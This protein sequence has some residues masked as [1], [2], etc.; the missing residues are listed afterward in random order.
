MGYSD[1]NLRSTLHILAIWKEESE[2]RWEYITILAGC[3]SLKLKRSYSL[4]IFL[5]NLYS[6]REFIAYKNNKRDL[7]ILLQQLARYLARA[8][9]KNTVAAKLVDLENLENLGHSP[10]ERSSSSSSST[11][12]HNALANGDAAQDE[13]IPQQNMAQWTCPSKTL[14]SQLSKQQQCSP[15]VILSFLK[16]LTSSV[17]WPRIIEACYVIIFR[18][19]LT[20]CDKYVYSTHMVA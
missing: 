17:S 6:Q 20:F 12:I 8:A 4:G 13:A 5:T 10:N 11:V 2:N 18:L 3:K 14:H 1:C 19:R 16:N 15:W 7:A 9:F